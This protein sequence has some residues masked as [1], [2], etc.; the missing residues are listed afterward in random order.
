LRDRFDELQSHGLDVVVVLCQ[1]AASVAAWLAKHPLPFPI[2]IDDDRSRAKRW[3]VYVALSYDSIH[4]A[5]PA[6]FIVDN[7][8]VIRYARI[9][10]HQLD[11]APLEEILAV[12]GAAAGSPS[13][14]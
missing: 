8:G 2:L 7:T 13:R 9:A 4:M 6:T 14:S 11:P 12:A 10:P 1:K 5:R 3:G